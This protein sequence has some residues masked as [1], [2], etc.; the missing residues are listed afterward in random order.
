MTDENLDDELIIEDEQT[1]E[2]DDSLNEPSTAEPETVGQQEKEADE[3]E[4]FSKRVQK[5]IDKLVY[6][7]NIEREERERERQENDKLRERLEQLETR[8]HED[9][10]KQQNDEINSRLSQLKARKAELYDEGDYNAAADIDDEIIELRLKQ[11]EAGQQAQRRET[12]QPAQPQARP[13]P[14]QPNIPEAQ[15]KWLEQN[16]W[17]FNPVKA[18]Q[19]QVANQAYLSLVDEGYDPNDPSTY[20]E[21][22]KRLNPKRETPPP[23][24]GVDRGNA[25]GSGKQVRFT[26]ADVNKLREWG[27]DPND[28]NVRKEYLRNKRAEA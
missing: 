14:A 7:R 27:L 28:V 23:T 16:D 15:V 5:R 18:Q 3:Q 13:E 24:N 8:Y 17:Y 20:K 1:N 11:R 21:L 9:N 12:G 6:E 10:T 26:Q 19:A 2:F 22:D 25:T 4:E